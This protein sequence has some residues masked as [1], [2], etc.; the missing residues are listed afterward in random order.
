M[1]NLT[2]L[3]HNGSGKTTLINYLLGFYTDTSQHPFLA[4]LTRDFA[5]LDTKTCGYAPESSYLDEQMCGKAYFDLIKSIKRSDEKLGDLFSLVGLKADPKLPLKKYSKGMKQRFLLALALIGK[6]EYLILDEP[7]SGLDIFG[8]EIIEALLLELNQKYRL[9]I[10]THSLEL[11]QKLG[12]EILLLKEGH[13]IFRGH[14]D[15]GKE[16]L[17]MLKQQAPKVIE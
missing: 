8:K 5:P 7:T 6:P 2:L 13:I 14:I 3:G 4:E 11:A 12:N 1:P 17:D 9:I 15:D 16:M 10:S